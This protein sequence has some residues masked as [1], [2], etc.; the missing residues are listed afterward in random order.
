MYSVRRSGRFHGFPYLGQEPA[1]PAGPGP[2]RKLAALNAGHV[3]GRTISMK[4]RDPGRIYPGRM[5]FS[6]ADPALYVVSAR[7]APEGSVFLYVIEGPGLGKW[8]AVSIP[9]FMTY[10]LVDEDDSVVLRNL[11]A[12][13]FPADV[14]P[15]ELDIAY[16]TGLL[17][18][19]GITIGE[20]FPVPAAADPANAAKYYEDGRN[21]VLLAMVL[22]NEAIDNAGASYD[23]LLIGKNAYN[24]VRTVGTEML[25][26]LVKIHDALDRYQSEGY[27]ALEKA[28]ALAHDFMSKVPLWGLYLDR[29]L[30]WTQI[31]DIVEMTEFREAARAIEGEALHVL[32]A[33][34]QKPQALLTQGL[35]PED[36]ASAKSYATALVQSGLE[37]DA[38]MEQGVRN[39][40]AR[41][42]I[43]H[44][45]LE[46]LNNLFTQ[47]LENN[48]DEI[49]K[50]V[51]GVIEPDNGTPLGFLFLGATAP[52]KPRRVQKRTLDAISILKNSIGSA[53][54]QLGVRKG[55]PPIPE[56]AKT[57]RPRLADLRKFATEDVALVSKEYQTLKGAGKRERNIH[58]VVRALAS[59]AKRIGEAITKN[60]KDAALKARHMEVQEALRI[61][62]SDASLANPTVL[63]H[64]QMVDDVVQKALAEL[65]AAT[66]AEA[67]E[68]SVSTVLSTIADPKN[69]VF[70]R[71]LNNPK[72]RY[73][74]VDIATDISWGL[75]LDQ[76][77]LR[78]L[79]EG[80]VDGFLPR[81]MKPGAK[82]DPVAR[83]RVMTAIRQEVKKRIADLE[84]IS[85][86]K[87]GIE[88][89]NQLKTIS[90]G[91]ERAVAKEKVKG[92]SEQIPATLPEKV[93]EL[94]PEAQDRIRQN[95]TMT[96]DLVKLYDLL[97]ALENE[98]LAP[99]P[100]STKAM[101]EVAAE[102]KATG[103]ITKKQIQKAKAAVVAK[104]PA[105]ARRKKK[106]ASAKAEA[107]ITEESSAA[108]DLSNA[109]AEE[110]KSVVELMAELEK[111]EKELAGKGDD[112]VAPADP[113]LVIKLDEVVTADKKATAAE[114]K[115]AFV[116]GLARFGRWLTGAPST[117]PKAAENQGRDRAQG[118]KLVNEAKEGMLTRGFRAFRRIGSLLG[119]GAISYAVFGG[120]HTEEDDGGT[121]DPKAS[122]PIPPPHSELEEYLKYGV[123]A[124]AGAGLLYFMLS[125]KKDT[126]PAKKK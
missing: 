24:L 80:I 56:I 44:D 45:D 75:G 110:E 26:A 123:I 125:K 18:N 120:G 121:K 84:A 15:D 49:R 16:L 67:L 42:E 7:P 5:V 96:E 99:R 72:A 46:V 38:R 105:V 48:A 117:R 21:G 108:R 78:S 61:A 51:E 32:S 39:Y 25:R 116:R 109:A 104:T 53:V 20:S 101:A 41:T 95:L 86:N 28:A 76:A 73:N 63:Q 29:A 83:E 88:L 57:I 87:L 13:H 19:A 9:E 112:V 22:A 31:T 55:L 64:Y 14:S 115:N 59:E 85:N 10:R 54:K 2:A 79:I 58:N 114:T 126:A 71:N 98:S 124:A 92:V 50:E 81:G 65:D 107:R 93:M 74:L 11:P 90:S 12:V 118:A 82:A 8:K 52:A 111:K 4:V 68:K 69:R 94:S 6:E 122:D 77:G 33:I 34:E 17:S 102:V 100:I 35:T 62:Q 1:P 3:S 66:T 23:A 27:P 113:N 97:S 47:F 60:P 91:P 43:A 37:K 119:L 30:L 40:L 106:A 103:K 89:T 36:L 70:L